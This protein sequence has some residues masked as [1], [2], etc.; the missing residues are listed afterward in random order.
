MRIIQTYTRSLNIIVDD[1]DYDR[2]YRY[3]YIV[4]NGNKWIYRNVKLAKI[5]IAND[6]TQVY[7]KT[8]DHIDHNPLNN[9]KFNLRVVTQSENALNRRKRSDSKSRFRGVSYIRNNA[10]GKRWNSRIQVGDKR[11]FLGTF[12]T[13][14]EAAKAYNDAASKYH[15]KFAQLNII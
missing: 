7:G 5:G 6:V 3:N 4:T 1:E 13:Q 14:L 10:Q 15:D 9:Q 12:N 8:I 11:L 2:L